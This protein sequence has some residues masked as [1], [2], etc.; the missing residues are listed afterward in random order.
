MNIN[1]IAVNPIM[2]TYTVNNDSNMNHEQYKSKK[3]EDNLIFQRLLE[4]E[5]K[6]QEP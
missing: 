1:D 6:K 5:M 2:P 4:E 3:K